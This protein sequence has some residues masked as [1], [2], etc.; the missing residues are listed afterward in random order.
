MNIKPILVCLL[1]TAVLAGRAQNAFFMDFDSQES[2]GPQNAFLEQLLSYEEGEGV[3]RIEQDARL[4]ERLG[5]P[6]VNVPANVQVVEG[7]RYLQLTGYRIQIFS[8]NSHAASKTEAFQKEAA[9]KAVVPELTTYVR[10]SAPFWRLRVG[11]FLTY[12]EAYEMLLRLRK[13]FVYGR[14]MSIVREKINIAL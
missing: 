14:E 5:N 10:Y 9:V 11:D 13:T 3:V 8:G 4:L 7:R 1:V 2:Q 12:E 6:G